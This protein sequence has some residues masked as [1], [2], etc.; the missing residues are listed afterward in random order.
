MYGPE[1]YVSPGTLDKRALFIPWTLGF[2]RGHT[3]FLHASFCK[4]LAMPLLPPYFDSD[5]LRPAS[6]PWEK[7][8]SCTEMGCSISLNSIHGFSR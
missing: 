5:S 3:F 1:L 7:D 2:K 4:L 8:A 6:L